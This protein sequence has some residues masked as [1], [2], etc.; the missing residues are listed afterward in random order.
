MT[1]MV[2]LVAGHEE[3][4]NTVNVAGAWGK[5][6][7]RGAD[8]LDG[9]EAAVGVDVVDHA[10]PGALHDRL[11]LGSVEQAVVDAPCHAVGEKRSAG[12]LGQ[13]IILL[14]EEAGLP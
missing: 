1:E 10:G 8:R 7:R 13:L 3:A 5:L 14:I 6:F 9:A 11:I 4:A 12:D 2:K